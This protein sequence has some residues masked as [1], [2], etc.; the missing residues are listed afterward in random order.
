MEFGLDDE[1]PMAAARSRVQM[2]TGE[3]DLGEFQPLAT[4]RYF[5]PDKEHLFFFVYSCELPEG[6]QLWHQAEMSPL[7]VQRTA[8]IRENQVLRKAL[9]LCQ[10][11]VAAPPG[12]RGGLRDRGD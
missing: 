10:A 4:G 11:R 12:P 9:A 5:H 8:G 7:S 6:L 2:E 3:A 1:I